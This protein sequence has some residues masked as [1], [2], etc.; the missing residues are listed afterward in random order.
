MPPRPK[1][2]RAMRTVSK[3]CGVVGVANSF[4]IVV[5]ARRN[6]AARKPKSN[7]TLWPTTTAP[8][9]AATTSGS[10]SANVGWPSTISCVMPVSATTPGAI[11]RHG[12]TSR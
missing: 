6:S 11:R 9:I 10:R 8:A 4:V 5:P 2:L 12:S 3:T 7:R 1:R